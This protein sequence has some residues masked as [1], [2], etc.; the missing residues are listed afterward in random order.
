MFPF[1]LAPAFKDYIWGG[2]RLKT[3]YGK[4]SEYDIVAESWELSAH[5]DGD[6]RIASGALMGMPF[7]AFVRTHPELLGHHCKGMTEFPILIKFIDAQ[8]VL[9]IQV[10]PDDIY[11]RRVEHEAGKTE[12]W[13]VLEAEPSAFLYYGFDRSMTPEEMSRRIADGSITDVM[14]RC[15]VAPGDVFFISA[16][17]LHAIGSGILLAEIQENSNSTYRVFDFGR[18]GPDGLPRPLHIEKALDV[19]DMNPS[20]LKAPG[21]QPPEQGE[22]YVI[23]RLSHCDYFTTDRLALTGK[24]DQTMDGSSF[25]SVL[26]TGGEAVLHCAGADLP[27]KKGDSIFAPSD[28]EGFTLTGQGAFLL[29]TI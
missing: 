23:E 1:L 22:G 20:V 4:Q 19:T 7:S 6:N 25:V 15:P 29:T 13:V 16:G 28:N 18:V 11:A 26:C 8:N 17:T 12:M 9:S 21:A 24:Y 5:K 3:E 27:V 14:R 2:T 10:H